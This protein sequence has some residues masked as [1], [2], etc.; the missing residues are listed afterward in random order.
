MLHRMN[1]GAIVSDSM[2]KV[3]F[4]SGGYI[5]MIEE[6][7]ISRLKPKTAF[8]LAGRVLEIA[9]IRDMTVYVRKSKSKRA[10]TP[11]WNGG[12]LPLTSYLSHFLRLKLADSLNPK[13]SERELKFLNPLFTTQELNSHIPKENEFLVEK[14]ESKDGFHIFFYP[15]EG[16]AVHE[17]MASLMA[18][19]ISKIKPI[20]FTIA[21]NDYGFDLLSD[22]EIPVNEENIHELLTTNNLMDD[23]IASINAT[24]MASRKFRDIATISGMVIQ[25][26]PR[27]NRSNKSLQSSSSLIFKVLQD[28][29][30]NNLLL[31]QAYTEV[32]NEQLEETR[33]RNAFDR[34]SK[35][36][37]I[38]KEAKGF[39]PLSFPIKVDSLRDTMSNEKL[40]DRIARLRKQQLKFFK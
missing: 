34:I 39:T 2:M 11:S 31:R 23:V 6:F 19:R 37:V 30:P 4:V 15:F 32:F 25:S 7:F 8:V 16:R 29:E 13:S 28:Y 24:E 38:L 36:K 10:I 1:I 12:R 21:M 35:N 22:Q 5:G 3:K 20:T 40:E 26:S 33:L 18:Y 9:F 14:I 17:V 27:A